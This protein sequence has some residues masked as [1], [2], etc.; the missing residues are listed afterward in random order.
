MLTFSRL[1]AAL[2]AAMSAV[3][4]ARAQTPSPAALTLEEAVRA[5]LANHPGLRSAAYDVEAARAGVRSARA[6]ANPEIV[7]TPGITTY[8]SDEEVLIRQP[9]EIN[10]VRKARTGVASAALRSAT[11]QSEA[12]RRDLIFETKSAY[13]A[14]AHARERATLARDLAAFADESDR[15]TRRQ[16]EVGALPGLDQMQTGIEAVRARQEAVRAESTAAEAQA[17]LNTAMGRPA[18]API[19][20][21][22]SL[23]SLPTAESNGDEADGSALALDRRAEVVAAEAEREGFRQEARLARAEG[24]PDL[25]PQFRA[26]TVTRGVEGVG[27]GLG[28]TLPFVDWGERRNRAGQAERSAEAQA[29]RAEALRAEARRD[30]LQARAR[31]RAA[32]IAV[33]TYQDGALEQARRL[34]DATRT[35]VQAGQTSI[36]ALLEAQRANRAVRIEYVDAL[37]DRAAA[38]AEL[39]RATHVL[40]TARPQSPRASNGMN[41]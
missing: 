28:I 2:L 31:L 14:L 21:L 41:P 3:A 37:A 13:I 29:L 38:A 15:L 1:C 34:V 26:E 19:G 4:V 23:A 39:E 22:S 12:A 35:G 25:A 7:F 18:E 27:L 10:G 9:L 5:A 24:R 6:L 17:A 32:E 20:A 8:G 11:A 33:K 30:A 16:V 36:L 40:P